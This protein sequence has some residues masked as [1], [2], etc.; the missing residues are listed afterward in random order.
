MPENADLAGRVSPLLAACVDEAGAAEG[1]EH[2]CNVAAAI[3]R[4]GT[5]SC[6]IFLRIKIITDLSEL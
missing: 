4:S 5:K 1:S 3:C 6:R 2:P